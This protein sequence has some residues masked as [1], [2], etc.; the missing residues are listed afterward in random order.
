MN[1]E[2]LAT[3]ASAGAAGLVGAAATDAWAATRDRFVALLGRG[4]ADRSAAAARRL[5]ALRDQARRE[6]GD[7]DLAQARQV[8]RVRLQDL[9]EEH[10][11]AAGELQAAVAA[12]DPPGRTATTTYQQY[13]RA[14]GNG[15]V[16]MNQHGD[17]SVHEG[18]AEPDGG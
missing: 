4:D 11:E 18:R 5:D 9:L 6:N 13:G 17:L 16:F 8:W 3:L 14:D 10:P 15:R 2:W 7:A 12:F 1:P